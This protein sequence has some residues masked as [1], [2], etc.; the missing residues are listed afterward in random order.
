M[1]WTVGGNPIPTPTFPPRGLQAA[2]IRQAPNCRSVS[3]LIPLKGRE[4]HTRVGPLPFKGRV[5][6]GMG[7][8]RQSI[9]RVGVRP[10]YRPHKELT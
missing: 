2:R 5:G 8:P 1:A 9:H 7:F 4:K 3:G 10:P 6:V